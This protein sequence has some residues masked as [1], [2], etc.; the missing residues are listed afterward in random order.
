MPGPS[1]TKP[2]PLPGWLKIDAH[3]TYEDTVAVNTFWL[4]YDATQAEA[5]TEADLDTIE[6]TFRND[7]LTYVSPSLVQQLVMTEIRM[8]LFRASGELAVS[9]TTAA[10]GAATNAALPA[11]VSA[12]VNWTTHAFYRG[13]KPKTFLPGLHTGAVSSSRL[14]Y[15]TWASTLES[16]M[17]SWLG[18]ASAYTSTHLSSAP[19]WIRPSWAIG[20]AYRTTA[21]QRQVYRAWVQPRMC[22]QRRRF[23]QPIE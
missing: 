3:Y 4:A 7:W 2:P 13:G 8:V 17:N 5:A 18:N 19:V 1:G 23:G 16:H 11:N 21:V 14:L 22:T 9:Y 10:A 12:V 15:A 20:K 6:A